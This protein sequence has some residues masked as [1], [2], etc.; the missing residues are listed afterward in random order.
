MVAKNA[1]PIWVPDLG[2]GASP[3][4]ATRSAASPLFRK[5]TDTVWIIFLIV[6]VYA[7][8]PLKH[9]ELERY[10]W[11]MADAAILALFLYRPIPFLKIIGRNLIVLSWPLLAI[12]ST[13]WSVAPGTSL[14]FGVQLLLTI[15]VGLYLCIYADLEHVLKLLFTALLISAVLSIIYLIVSPGSARWYHGELVGVFPHKNVLGHVMVLLIFTGLCLFLQGWRPYLAISGA[16]LGLLLL[17][18]SRSGVGTV[19]LA[20]ALAVFPIGILYRAGPSLLTLAAGGALTLLSAALLI[21]EINRFDLMQSV[22]E[23]LG[24]DASLTGRTILWDFAMDAYNTRP[25]L[26]FGYRGY[27]SNP[28]PSGVSTLHFIMGL[29]VAFFHNCFIETLV[30]F[31]ILGPILL[32]AGLIVA[33]FRAVRLFVADPQYVHLWSIIFL[34]L[35]VVLAYVENPLFQNHGIHQL[36]FAVAAASSLE[37]RRTIA[38]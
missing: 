13:I 15:L 9:Y 7:T 24:K 34:A 4:S 10:A 8:N 31:G 2:G 35:V 19:V 29:Q 14:W 30:A 18:M 3:H 26:G 16:I 37:R 33:F 36:L 25:W 21:V 32:T 17:G 11:L 12:V 23:A 5:L 20:L 6:A 1:I 22:L 28:D 27:W 38:Q